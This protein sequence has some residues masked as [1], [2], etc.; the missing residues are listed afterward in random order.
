MKY[1]VKFIDT[2]KGRKALI[3]SDQ[4]SKVSDINMGH[5]SVKDFCDFIK[6]QNPK[7]LVFDSGWDSQPLD[8]IDI[9]GHFTYSNDKQILIYTK[10]DL[11]GFNANIGQVTKD[12]Y[13]G[14]ANIKDLTSENSLAIVGSAV[15]DLLIS[16]TYYVVTDKDK[17]VNVIQGG[18]DEITDS[19]N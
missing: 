2:D 12:R 17:M 15:L 11:E 10:S 19:K 16:E 1:N 4:L 8:L 6:L 13:K 14:E 5:E 3:Y 18:E 9:L 7:L